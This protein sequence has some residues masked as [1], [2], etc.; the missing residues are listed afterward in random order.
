VVGTVKTHVYNICQKLSARNRT[1]A[2][3]RARA[4]HLL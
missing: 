3:L 1:Q 4:L 2:V